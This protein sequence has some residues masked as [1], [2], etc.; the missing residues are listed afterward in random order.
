ML[1]SP[2][3]AGRIARRARP[4]ASFA[5]ILRDLLPFAHRQMDIRFPIGLADALASH[6]RDDR[7]ESLARQALLLRQPKISV[8]NIA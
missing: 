3:S 7:A 1:P 2:W 6:D 4:R 8:H 5:P